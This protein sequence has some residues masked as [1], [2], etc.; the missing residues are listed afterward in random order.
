MK[1]YFISDDETHSGG[2]AASDGDPVQSIAGQMHG[3]SNP[4]REIGT[5]SHGRR[6]WDHSEGH[7]DGFML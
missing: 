4:S 1:P 5:R 2:L 7:E 6:V 3:A